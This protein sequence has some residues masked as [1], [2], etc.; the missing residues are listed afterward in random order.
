VS[1]TLV[2]DHQPVDAEQRAQQRLQRQ[3]LTAVGTPDYLAPEI[4]LGMAHDSSS[5]AS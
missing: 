3:R 4:L 2:G 1:S 5:S